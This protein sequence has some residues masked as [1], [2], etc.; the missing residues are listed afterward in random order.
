M[1]LLQHHTAVT[2]D[3][4]RTP[5][6]LFGSHLKYVKGHRLPSQF[7]DKLYVA[8][9]LCFAYGQEAIPVDRQL[10]MF[11]GG[12]TVSREEVDRM[13]DWRKNPPMALPHWI[14]LVGRKV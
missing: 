9:I 3:I 14:C 7:V 13:Y 1:D 2:Q 12:A 11:I 4:N 6:A 10:T 8:G 5:D